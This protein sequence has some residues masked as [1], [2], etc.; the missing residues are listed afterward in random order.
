MI[1]V[2][3]L[4]PA[5]KRFGAQEAAKRDADDVAVTGDVYRKKSNVRRLLPR[6]AWDS[7][8]VALSC[9]CAR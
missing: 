2:A 5:P 8:F 9:F 1:V 4:A 7:R 3:S 6:L